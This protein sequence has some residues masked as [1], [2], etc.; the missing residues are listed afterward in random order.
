MA[1][2]LRKAGAAV[3]FDEAI[4]GLRRFYTTDAV[5]NRLEFLEEV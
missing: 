3:E 5:G 1:E 2:T 4:P